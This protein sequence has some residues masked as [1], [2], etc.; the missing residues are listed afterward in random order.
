M[1]FY[2]FSLFSWMAY[3]VFAF[4]AIILLW[5]VWTK[6]LGL[7]VR[8]PV[9]WIL[10]AAI[11]VGPW[12]EE[13]WIAYNFGQLCR[14]DAGI[15]IRRTVN[16]DGF[17]DDTSGWGPW[18]LQESGYRFV[19]SKDM[20]DH[21]LRR[22]ERVNDAMRDRA[23]AGYASANP[24]AVVSK[25]KYLDYQVNDR[26]R[27]YVSPDKRMAWRVTR[28]DK[29]TARYRYTM[30]YEH[31]TVAHRIRK[32]VHLV[33]DSETGE[34]LGRD[35]IYARDSYWFFASLDRPVMLCPAPGTDPLER[36]GLIY[37]QT[38]RPTAAY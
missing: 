25:G 17:Y 14:G 11:V 33:S 18:Q 5:L 16:V 23:I 29:P 19:E 20:L 34:I 2:Y 37:K 8:N 10:V 24:G 21:K 4:I 6:L 12:G 22:V 30:P 27:I 31:T 28:I 26:E 7:K 38:L 1:R 36:Y 3:A 35:A 9:Y 32:T 15:S 13:I